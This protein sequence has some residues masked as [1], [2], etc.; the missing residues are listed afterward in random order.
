MDLQIQGN[1]ALVTASS[2]GLGKASAMVLAQEGANVVING[3]D[4]KKL[5]AAVA[6][7][8][9]VSTGTVIG[10]QGDITSEADIRSLVDRTLD[11]FGGIDHL[12]TSAGGPPSGAFM[13]TTD[14]DWDHAHDLLLM[15]V[16]RLVRESADAL[17]SDGG[18][19]IVNITSRS[20]KEAIPPIALSNSVRMGVVGLEKTLSREFAP[21]V[22]ANAVLPGPHE[23]DRIRLLI[24]NAVANGEYDSYEDGLADRT[25]SVP[26]DMLGDPMNLG[27]MVAFL[28]SPCSQFINGTTVTIDGGIGR[29]TL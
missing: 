20:I 7:L 15:S 17:R 9:D 4:E 1:T 11:E 29:A 28:S 18:G 26:V 12:V 27:Q 13:D 10:Q 22:R 25:D 14:E 5:E 23:T 21:E 6:D 8:R 24:E 16:V 2:D 3:R 19:T